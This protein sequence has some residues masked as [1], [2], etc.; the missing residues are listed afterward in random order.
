MIS[1]GIVVGAFMLSALSASTTPAS[2]SLVGSTISAELKSL[3]GL[4]SVTS[5]F[6]PSSVVIGSGPEFQGAVLMAV[7]LWEFGIDVDIAASTINIGV[8]N[9]VGFPAF[10]G[11]ASNL[12]EIKLS[13]LP[14]F[15][16]AIDFIDYTCSGAPT[17]CSMASGIATTSFVNSVF[18]V[19]LDSLAERQ[20]YT[21]AVQETHG[22]PEPLAISI[23][24]AGVSLIFA[25]HRRKKCRRPEEV[26]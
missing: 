18:T 26:R 25:G 2:A 21:F 6:S 9:K 1:R 20:V 16:S 4:F 19:R 10:V 14:S 13:D 11:G 15:V 5:Q 12:L 22:A 8:T 7:K 3:N 24:G 23:F 17:P